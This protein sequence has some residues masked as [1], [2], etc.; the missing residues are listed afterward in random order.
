MEVAGVVMVGL[1]KAACCPNPAF[2][3]PTSSCCVWNKTTTSPSN[4][5]LTILH[6]K[7]PFPLRRANKIRQLT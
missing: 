1:V 3:P 2:S 5:T 7:E 4:P 6:I